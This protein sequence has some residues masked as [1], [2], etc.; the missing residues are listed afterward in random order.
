MRCALL[1][2]AFLCF[3]PCLAVNRDYQRIGS[4]ETSR[5][6]LGLFFSPLVTVTYTTHYAPDGHVGGSESGGECLWLCWTGA[7]LV[8][9][10]G[11]LYASA[12]VGRRRLKG[13]D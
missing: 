1:V 3:A 12:F 9:G 7:L 5:W 11:F 2:A 10:T 8:A 6:S 4:D 13:T